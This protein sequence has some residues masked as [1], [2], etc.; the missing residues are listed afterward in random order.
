MFCLCGFNSIRV[1]IL[2]QEN[3]FINFICMLYVPM[4]FAVFRGHSRNL[5]KGVRNTHDTCLI[6]EMM[7]TAK[8]L[9]INLCFLFKILLC[10]VSR[11]SCVWKQYKTHYTLTL[12]HIKTKIFSWLG[13]DNKSKKVLF[14]FVYAK[15]GSCNPASP[16]RNGHWC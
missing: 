11:S 7:V 12:S 9:G 13:E 3:K 1:Y 2:M 5:I 10:N 4:S 16:G 8:D 14:F 15:G 6:V